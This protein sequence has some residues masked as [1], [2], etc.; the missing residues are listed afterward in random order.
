MEIE[1]QPAMVKAK[2][3]YLKAYIMSVIL[4]PIG[5]YY[6]IKYLFFSNADNSDF[7]A[8]I[9]SLV[10][11]TISLFLNIW[12]IK[13]FFNQIGLFSSG[14]ISNGQNMD[15]LKEFITPENQKILKQLFE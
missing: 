11:T 7:K 3:G 6:F 2:Q 10:L 5:L 1:Q 8:G 9:I 4:P 15:F 13:V 14:N 12:L